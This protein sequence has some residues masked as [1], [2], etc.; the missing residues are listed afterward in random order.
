MMAVGIVDF[1]TYLAHSVSGGSYFPSRKAMEEYENLFWD[2]KT[3]SG[4]ATKW[5][6]KKL[7][8]YAL[9][10]RIKQLGGI[11]ES[12][13]LPDRDDLGMAREFLTILDEKLEC[14]TPLPEARPSSV[15]A[16]GVYDGVLAGD[17]QI[18]FNK[19][20]ES[21]RKMLQ[22]LNQQKPERPA[23][24]RRQPPDKTPVSRPV[25]PPAPSI[26]NPLTESNPVPHEPSF[27]GDTPNLPDENGPMV[28]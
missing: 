24:P 25:A 11:L 15:G 4:K 27:T 13:Q 2:P 16:Q 9:E 28:A 3:T 12:K 14:R 26:R 18:E 1:Q 17:I 5:G 21:A 23:T 22:E 10:K 20:A 8:D 19:L 7:G 6:L